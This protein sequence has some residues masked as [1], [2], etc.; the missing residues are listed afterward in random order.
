VGRSPPLPGH[1]PS[2]RA[3][4]GA[5]TPLRRLRGG[6]GPG[7]RRGGP[8]GG[9]DPGLLRPGGPG[10]GPGAPAS[11]PP[12]AP[13]PGRANAR[14]GGPSRGGGCRARE[15]GPGGEPPHPDGL[16]PG[17]RLAGTASPGQPRLPGGALGGG[18]GG[19]RD[20]PGRPHRRV[21]GPAV[22]QDRRGGVRGGGAGGALPTGTGPLRGV[23]FR[24]AGGGGG[25]SPAAGGAGG[26]RVQRGA[27]EERRFLFPRWRGA[28]EM[29]TWLEGGAGGA[30][31][32]DLYARL[33][34]A[35]WR[36]EAAGG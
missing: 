8:P 32:G 14:R 16:H 29:A 36:E 19:P 7:L 22:L 23:R 3:P 15:G 2:A 30:S 28:G 21:R 27:G 33:R 12:L 20:D 6:G 35:G 31:S 18:G 34:G 10:G 5:P 1:L 4:A 9:P 26:L 25:L 13:A 17:P 11:P 24:G